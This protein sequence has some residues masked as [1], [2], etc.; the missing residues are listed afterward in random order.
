MGTIRK[1]GDDYFIE[2][3]ARGL[4]YQQKAGKDQAAAEN[5]LKEIESKIAKGELLTVVRQIQL[6]SFWENF[7]KEAESKYPPRT[8]ERLARAVNH[9]QTFCQNHQAK[10]QNLSEITPS[11]IEEY[12]TQLIKTLKNDGS[13]KWNP[14]LINLTLLLIR[15]ALEFGIKTG[16]INDNPTLHIS[17]LE[18]SRKPSAYILAKDQISRITQRASLTLSLIVSFLLETGITINELVKTQWADVDW[19]QSLLRVNSL[20]KNQI[21]EIPLSSAA[22]LILREL[23]EHRIG[24]AEF[25]FND[26]S[27][28]NLVVSVLVKQLKAA[29]QAAEL[30]IE[31]NFCYFRRAFAMAR[32]GQGLSIFKLAHILG[33]TDIG[34]IMGYAAWIP[35][36][37]DDAYHASYTVGPKKF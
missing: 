32:L 24:T 3:H 8:K 4:L 20:K 14:K 13:R 6:E 27:G 1:I 9:F 12:K 23:A 30:N 5:L 19:K 10:L 17:L 33:C 31:L 29:T 22:I 18:I 7:L 34:Q 16:F 37:R 26:D 2:F 28:K 21:R 11:V 36:Y 25:I 15:E 35:L